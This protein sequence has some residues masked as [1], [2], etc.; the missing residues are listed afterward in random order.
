MN[1]L[2][3]A[4]IPIAAATAPWWALKKRAGWRE[5]FGVCEALPPKTSGRILLHAVSV[6]EVNA[7]RHLV[8][9]LTR[10]AEVVISATT[11]TGHARANDLFASTCRIVRFPLDFSWA[12]ARVL[13]A[14]QP[15][16]VALVE[17]E[18]WPNFVRAC[19]QRHI[20]VCVIN[21]RLSERSF[22]GYNRIAGWFGAVLKKL[23]FVAA[24]DEDY[25]ARFVRLGM[26][27]NSVFL[28]GSMKWDSARIEDQVQG[29]DKL[30]AELGIDPHRPL[31]V[32][33]S[34]GPGEEALLLKACP[35]QAQLLCAPR[36][37]DRFDEAAAA[38]P[39]CI[40]RSQPQPLP[41]PPDSARR[42][43]LLDSIGELRQAYSLATVAVIGRS[44]GTL[45][46]S[47]PIE[48]IAL[49]KATVIGPAVADFAQIVGVFERAGGILK[50]DPAALGT[51]LT[52][53]LADPPRRAQLG[54]H[55][56]E[57]IRQEQGAS[58]RHAALLLDL[59][60]SARQSPAPDIQRSAAP[61]SRVR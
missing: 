29:A 57:C 5:R 60:A 26:D 47:D 3:L 50:T 39:G 25:A 40:R 54:G 16:A 4:Y 8:P 12:V 46:G 55:G 24:Q 56:R 14:V 35:P 33:G 7:L 31:I 37:P 23:E 34:T 13:D 51:T 15:D 27:P 11:D 10:H 2:D 53:L 6:G 52:E 19:S 45:Y 32:A 28:T 1:A 48:A 20:P 58:E 9:M 43:F 59:C 21:G 41:R 61:D 17:L 30:A 42:L 18:V 38:L 22:K 36:K 44:F 49:G